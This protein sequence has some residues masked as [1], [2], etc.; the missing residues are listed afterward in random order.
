MESPQFIGIRLGNILTHLDIHIEEDS[1][2]PLACMVFGL[3]FVV[4]EK[5]KENT[6]EAT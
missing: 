4:F 1:P 2:P 5:V 3:A 6:K